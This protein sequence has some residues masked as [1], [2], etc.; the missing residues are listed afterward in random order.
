MR[1]VFYIFIFSQLLNL[2]DVLAEKINK[3]LSEQKIKRG[4]LRMKIQII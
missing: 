1:L 4:G 2:L 3:E